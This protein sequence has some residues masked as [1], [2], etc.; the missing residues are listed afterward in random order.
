MNGMV[1]NSSDAAGHDEIGQA[2]LSITRSGHFRTRRRCTSN[3]LIAHH[4][5]MVDDP[6]EMYICTA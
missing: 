6:D 5:C 1:A 3:A 4:V 2:R